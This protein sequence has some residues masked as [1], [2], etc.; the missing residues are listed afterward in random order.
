MA[1][2]LIFYSSLGS[3]HMSAAQALNEAFRRKQGVDVQVEDALVY[4]GGLFRA[5]MTNWYLWISQQAPHSIGLVLG[6]L[7]PN[8]TEAIQHC[9]GSVAL[10]WGY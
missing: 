10:E 5:S 8:A 2:I 4:G 9:V 7:P 3:G 6:L 1:R